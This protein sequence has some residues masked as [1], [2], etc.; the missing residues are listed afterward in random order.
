M[1]RTGR[2]IPATKGVQKPAIAQVPEGSSRRPEYCAGCGRFTGYT[3]SKPNPNLVLYCVACFEK[4][5]L[6]VTDGLLRA[7]Q[8]IAAERGRLEEQLKAALGSSQNETALRFARQLCGIEEDAQI[9]NAEQQNALRA[10][11]QDCGRTRRSKLRRAWET[12]D[13]GTFEGSNYLQQLA[14]QFGQSWLSNYQLPAA[15]D[16]AP[17]SRRLRLSAGLPPDPSDRAFFNSVLKEADRRNRLCQLVRGAVLSGQTDRALEFARQLC[18]IGLDANT[19]N[20]EAP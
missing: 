9:P 18:G 15:Q 14:A 6:P 5:P 12:G 8:T 4:T 2:N 16:L 1:K 7:V 10:W 11:V 17:K 19:P 13:F 20:T 3:Q